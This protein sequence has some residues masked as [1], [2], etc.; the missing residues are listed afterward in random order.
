[1][2]S[3]NSMLKTLTR[4]VIGVAAC[5]AIAAPMAT[6]SASTSHPAVPA[7]NAAQVTP[8]VGVT[9]QHEMVKPDLSGQ[10]DKFCYNAD[11][12]CWQWQG[13]GTP[14]I[15]DSLY[16]PSIFLP[17]DNEG[18]GWQLLRDTSTGLC[19][20]LNH[21]AGNVA[22]EKSCTSVDY[23]LWLTTQI[24]S[25]WVFKNKW[26]P[27]NGYSCTNGYAAAL[28][29]NGNG[30]YMTMQCPSSGGVYGQSELVTVTDVG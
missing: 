24:G 17:G 25:K 4:A 3:E 14:Y 21:S 10:D 8:I 5:L 9:S 16:S 26:L 23:Q 27:D 19:V 30:E 2:E 1:M 12:G 15:A 22:Y 11:G 28:G 7:A 6:A 18:S 29:T 13:G 20:S